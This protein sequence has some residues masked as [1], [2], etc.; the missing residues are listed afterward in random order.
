[1]K[2]IDTIIWSAEE[3]S[4]V[5]GGGEHYLLTNKGFGF[6]P[7]SDKMIDHFYTRIRKNE[8]VW[9]ALYT[10]KKGIRWFGKVETIIPERMAPKR[11]RR[12][13][14]RQKNTY[15]IKLEYVSSLP[16][17]IIN[18][19]G[20]KKFRNIKYSTFASILNAEKTSQLD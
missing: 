18:D 13:Q 11:S 20:S 8:P 14:K 16:H 12:E 17:N 9:F 2:E 10:A 4:D 6:Q 19:Q 1:M 3:D 7:I 15:F 5:E